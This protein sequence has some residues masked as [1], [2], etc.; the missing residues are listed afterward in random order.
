VNNHARRLATAAIG[1]TACAAAATAMTA[2]VDA[3]AAAS[4]VLSVSPAH[5]DRAVAA[6]TSYFVHS[7]AVVNTGD[8]AISAWVDPVD[9]LTS[10]RTGAV[11]AARTVPA[12]GTGGWIEP[13]VSSV[14]VGAHQQTEVAFTVRVPLGA[15]IGDHV[16][17]IAFESKHGLSAGG[18]TAITTVLRSVVAVQV[19]VPGPASFLLTVYGASVGAVAGTSGIAVDMANTG[20][21][22]AKPHLE[23][24]LD[25]PDGYH[26][27]E[28]VQLDTMLP[29]DRITDEFLWPDTL[30]AGDYRLAVTEDGSGRR[31]T[32]FITS[33]RVAAALRPAGPRPLSEVALAPPQSYPPVWIL[34]L[35]GAAGAAVVIIAASLLIPRRRQPRRRRPPA[36]QVPPG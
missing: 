6:G 8:T 20:G 14:V 19:R 10:I 9:A 22:L 26:H 35:L 4:T 2:A 15:S 30:P 13:G 31:G 25:G 18:T 23:I 32:T 7:L 24:V 12:E 34:P 17:G 29:N 5:P 3:A 1:V 28:G 21:L 16:A 33:A 11:Y 27:S 36:P